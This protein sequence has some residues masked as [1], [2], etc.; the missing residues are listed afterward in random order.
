[1]S[2]RINTVKQILKNKILH[3]E[4]G[5]IEGT[6]SI[7]ELVTLLGES[8]HIV[9]AALKELEEEKFLICSPQKGFKVN[10]AIRIAT[11]AAQSDRPDIE[12][13]FTEAQSWQTDFW[14]RVIRKFESR[15]PQWRIKPYFITETEKVL[16]FLGKHRN[17][18]V[19]V[20]RFPDELRGRGIS[21]VPVSE[22]E[23]NS[24]NGFRKEDII[25][26]LQNSRLSDSMPYLLQP[27]MLFYSSLPNQKKP[28]TSS[29]LNLM[30]WI[31][32]CYGS[33]SVMPVNTTLMLRSIGLLSRWKAT[34]AALRKKLDELAEVLSFIREN[35][36]Y[37]V[38]LQ[39]SD[40]FE[41][42]RRQLIEQSGAAVRNSF[43]FSALALKG[44]SSTLKLHSL[45][46]AA[47][48]SLE[49]PCCRISM[50]APECTRPAAEFFSFILSETVQTALL[51][52][53]HGLSPY[54]S[55][56]RRVIEQPESFQP[57]FA[58]VA[59]QMLNLPKTENHFDNSAS[60]SGLEDFMTQLLTDKLFLPLLSSK[61]TAKELDTLL[62]DLLNQIHENYDNIHQ[63]QYMK[64][65]RDLLLH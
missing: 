1:M 43:Y 61:P 46:L 3:G 8:R 28:D 54:R 51:K 57:G 60:I 63:K 12:A 48:G 40:R 55:Y 34:D 15:N 21:L 39:T 6:P 13:V 11:P 9:A 56:T 31:K 41:Q 4:P 47:D 52:E 20:V 65:L 7:R 44:E 17:T 59:E 64:S 23:R 45:P 5:F 25:P 58:E 42:A 27:S 29:W 22:I 36:L 19:V 24:K 53:C 14:C 2:K 62:S 50:A 30:K 26:E 37:N 16:E 38:D 49:V 33:H 18:P 32:H 10:P 35:K